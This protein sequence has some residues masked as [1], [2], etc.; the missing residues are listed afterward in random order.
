[1]R[2][3]RKNEAN[4]ETGSQSSQDTI[5]SAC[6][7]SKIWNFGKP[8]HRCKHC[9]ALLWYEERL[10]PKVS[11]KT[12]TFGMC[13]KQGKIRLPPLKKPPQYLDNLLNGEGKDSKN[14]RENIRSYNSMFSFT[15]TGGIVDRE[16]NN[17]HGPYVFR[18][19]GQNY[20]HIGTLIPKEGSKP[21]WR[22]YTSTILRTR[23]KT[24]SMHQ[25]PPTENH[26]LTP[27]LLQ[28]FRA[29]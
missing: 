24:G 5:K 25:N 8:T 4:Q 14:F 19:H 6:D 15:S 18:L 3:Q 7:T 21:R 1:M 2:E 11:T 29:C 22:S 13:C 27:I 23:Y 12:P 20:H 26:R 10:R 9:N 28:A 16:I 17:G